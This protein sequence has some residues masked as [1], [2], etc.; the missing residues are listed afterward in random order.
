MDLHLVRLPLLLRV[1]PDLPKSKRSAV[2]LSDEE[3]QEGSPS[4]LLPAG[5][6]VAASDARWLVVEAGGCFSPPDTTLPCSALRMKS[7]R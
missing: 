3:V 6:L 2:S 5:W 4:L 1:P 7:V